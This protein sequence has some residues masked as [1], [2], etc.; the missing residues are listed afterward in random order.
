M[1]TTHLTQHQSA[2]PGGGLHTA[3]HNVNTYFPMWAKLVHAR[4]V[5]ACLPHHIFEKGVRLQSHA[6]SRAPA[7][8]RK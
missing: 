8:P 7:H 5:R 4:Y 2:V 6:L 1:C 3:P